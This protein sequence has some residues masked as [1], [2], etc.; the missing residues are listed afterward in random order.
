MQDHEKTLLTLLAIGCLIGFSKL[1]VSDE[2]L[3]IRLLFGR[4]I[5]G[6]AT[7]LIAGVVLLQLPEINPL[8]LVGIAASLGILGS[9]FIEQYL[10]KLTKKWGG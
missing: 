1:L 3:S 5:L 9:T 7:S 6:G 8:A 2:P 4:T 10:K